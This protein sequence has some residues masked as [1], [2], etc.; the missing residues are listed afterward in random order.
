MKS[1]FVVFMIRKQPLQRLYFARREAYA[2]RSMKIVILGAGNIGSFLASALSEEGHDVIVIDRD[3][4]ALEKIGRS[5]DVATRLG[6]GTDWPL[7]EDLAE[8]SPDL[9]IAMSSD[10]ETNLV[11]CTIAKNVGFLKT[12]ARIRQNTFLDHSRLDFRHLF[13]VDH[14]IGTELIV[15]HDI[16]KCIIHPGHLAVENFAHGAVQMRTVVIPDN[17]AGAGKSLSQLNLSD[18]LLVGLIRRKVE[19]GKQKV[20][21]PKGQDLLLAGDEATLIGETNVMHH[22]HKIFGMQ[23]KT[24]G[25]V[26][27]VG[28]S[29]VATHLCKLLLNQ[30]IE[31]KVIEQDE[32][33]CQKFAKL[34]PK[35]MILNHDG[36]DFDFMREERIHN[37]DA[38]VACTQSHE[39]NILAAALA[40]Q[41]GCEEVI[42]LV[43][44]ESSAPLL[45]RLGISYVLSERASVAGRIY[46]I[47]HDNAIVSVASLYEDQAKIM[48]I[49]LSSSSGIVGSP[50]SDLS[51]TLPQNFLI[52]MIENRTGVM[53][54][55]G[56]SVLTPGDTAI[57]ICSP[58]SVQEV[59][60][61]L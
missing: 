60:K 46:S 39:T 25:S 22:L 50:I 30:G 20:I 44:D 15:A 32:E 37:S 9:F 42:A 27:L 12:V 13:H 58:E 10:D 40:K 52:A 55:K 29:G 17:Y 49:K 3:A 53:I 4:K 59:E 41:A 24:V 21:F 18:N 61:M 14:V 35:A 47:L 1:T 36:T 48:E 54:P 28:G 31:V 57:V 6:S 5:A 16:F 8:L 33:K 7:L 56:A 38:F 19:G 2:W 34:F 51:S 26:V 11:A 23:K 43:C 45:K